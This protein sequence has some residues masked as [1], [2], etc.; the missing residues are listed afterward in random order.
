[1]EFEG[2]LN[3]CELV[4]A[5]LNCYE[6]LG[7]LN[8]WEPVRGLNCCEP[9]GGLNYCELLLNCCKLGPKEVPYDMFV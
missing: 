5:K 3:Y 1:M 7:G 9:V 4:G 6:L 2:R 8:C